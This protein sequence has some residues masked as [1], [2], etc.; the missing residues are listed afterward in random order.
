MKHLKKNKTMKEKLYYV[1][2]GLGCG[3]RIGISKE[4]VYKDE[5]ASVGSYNGVREV[6]E[7]TKEDITWD[8]LPYKSDSK[9]EYDKAFRYNEHIECYKW[10]R[11]EILKLAKG[12]KK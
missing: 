8:D 2:T 12:A 7:A 4:Q 11:N 5:L 3:I 10:L 1:K 6:R 9:W